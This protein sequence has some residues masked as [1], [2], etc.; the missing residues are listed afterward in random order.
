MLANLPAERKG[1]FFASQLFLRSPLEGTCLLRA[2]LS[3]PGEVSSWDLLLTLV[4]ECEIPQPS[5]LRENRAQGSWL[6][7]D[8]L[9]AERVST[10]P[11][12]PVVAKGASSDSRE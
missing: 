9:G 3:S 6:G 4:M 7:A 12:C 5:V 8:A 1:S 11:I 2:S 10:I